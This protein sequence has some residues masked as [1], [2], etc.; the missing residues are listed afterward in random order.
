MAEAATATKA[1]TTK[2]TAAKKVEDLIVTVSHE[3][4][5]LSRDDAYSMAETL[6]DD[7]EFNNFKLGGVL[8]RIYT[9][10]WYTEE[11]YE[12]FKDFVEAKFGIKRSKAMYLISIYN[13]LVESGVAWNDVK[14]VG[15][16]KLKELAPILTKKNVKGW[17][18][19]ASTMTVIQ[20]IAYIKEQAKKG[21]TTGSTADE[22]EA[23]KVSSLT[24]KL[25]EDQREVVNEALEK[26][27]TESNSEYPAV[28]LEAICMGY[29]AG[30]LKVQDPND[31]DLTSKETLKDVMSGFT[32]EDVLAVFEEIWPD[33]DLVVTEPDES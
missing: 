27:K 13:S 6:V 16:S 2:T 21:E 9:E 20:L 22:T 15:W 19:R 28:A 33:V 17:V 30:P 8:A 24:F 23:K 14:D 4:E 26:A 5:N 32:W 7:G 31:L 25:H 12:H 1:K 3:V 11:G 10:G 29:L 18:K